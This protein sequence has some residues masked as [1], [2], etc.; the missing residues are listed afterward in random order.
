VTYSITREV[1]K[2]VSLHKIRAWRCVE[3]AEVREISRSL[4]S[5]CRP[6]LA[7]ECRSGHPLLSICK[8]APVYA[9]K[10]NKGHGSRVSLIIDLSTMRK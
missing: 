8:V 4:P 10:E 9:M 7:V 5:R 2:A 1:V 3:E 6:T